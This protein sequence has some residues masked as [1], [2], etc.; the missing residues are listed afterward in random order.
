MAAIKGITIEIGADTKKLQASLNAV[1]KAAGGTQTE[2]RQIERLLKLDPKN[3]ELLA[4]KQQVLGKALENSKKK[5]EE[6]KKADEELQ[7]QSQKDEDWAERQRLLQREIIKTQ[8]EINRLGDEVDGTAGKM[9]KLGKAGDKINSAMSAT[10]KAYT[11]AVV[12][13][14]TAAISLGMAFEESMAGASTLFGD[15]NVD[16]EALNQKMLE[17]SERTNIAA[18]ALGGAL[19]NALSAGVPA[20]DDMSEALGFLEGSAKLAKAGFTDIDTAMSATVKTLNAYGLGMEHADTVQKILI[21]TQNKG[22]TTVGQLG[23]AL[24]QV[25]PTAAAMNVSFDQVGAAIAN[26]TARGT[27]TEQSVTQLNALF[28]ELG[29]SGT[30]AQKSLQAATKGTEYAGKGFSELMAEGV[31]LSELLDLISDYAKKNNKSMLDMFSSIEA[32]KAALSNSAEGAAGFNEALA[33]MG[34]T[35]DVVGEAYDKVTN[36]SSERFKASINDLKNAAISLFLDMQPQISGFFDGIRKGIE[37]FTAHKTGVI[38][39]IKAIGAGLLTWNAVQVVSKTVTAISAL[40]K[41]LQAATAAQTALN[42]AQMTNVIGLVAA[43]IAALTT[44]VVSLANAETAAEKAAREEA[45]ALKELHEE[46]ENRLEE[47]KSFEAE[48]DRQT[49][50]DLE[51]IETTKKLAEELRT[52]AD[53]SGYVQE[54][55]RERAEF[56]LREL[57]SALGT[58]AEM[59]DGV[60]QKYNELQ[61]SIVGAIQAKEVEALMEGAKSKYDEAINNISAARIAQAEAYKRLQEV[62]EKHGVTL[63]AYNANIKEHAELVAKLPSLYDAAYE[64]GD[65]TEYDKI[66]NRISELN[67]IIG[68]QE[69]FIGE[70]AATYKTESERVQQ[71]SDDIYNYSHAT[72]LAAE[73]NYEGAISFLRA[74]TDG[75]QDAASAQ[76]KYGEDTEA[77]LNELLKTYQIRLAQVADAMRIYSETGTEDAKQNLMAALSAFQTAAKEYYDAGGEV[78][79]GFAKGANGTTLDLNPILEQLR[80]YVIVVPDLGQ[81]FA[82]GFIR[83]IKGENGLNVSAAANAAAQLARAALSGIRTEADIHSPSKETGYLGQDFVAGFVNEIAAGEK[84]AEKAAEG[85]AAA[86]VEALARFVPEGVALSVKENTWEVTDETKKHFEDLKLQRDINAISEAEYYARLEG[87]RDSYLEKGTKEWWDY[88]KDLLSYQDKLSDEREKEAEKAQKELE[89]QLEEA[90]K[91]LEKAK[92][93]IQDI[94]NDIADEAISDLEDVISA[95]TSFADKLKGTGDLYYQ[96]TTRVI[97][98]EETFENT[99][100]VLEDLDAQTKMLEDYGAALAAL[101]ERGVPRELLD[102]LQGMSLEEGAGFAGLLLSQ[103]DADFDAYIA[104]WK[105]KQAAAD[106]VS[107]AYYAEDVEN[108]KENYVKGMRDALGGLVLDYKGLGQ[109]Y[110]VAIG[111]GFRSGI[112]SVAAEMQRILRSAMPSIGVVPGQGGAVFASGG[113]VTNTNQTYSPTFNIYNGKMTPGQLVEASAAQYMRD[114]L[115]GVIK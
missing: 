91:K 19:Y 101:R 14:G 85:L 88:T 80:G 25:T 79:N 90:Q 81:D 52:L 37:W 107:A 55:D 68:E 92:D 67:V 3:T 103:S 111:D 29:K 66:E 6:L 50:S 112:A 33:A 42:A 28:A 51:R 105:R 34:T 108:V 17:L 32:G 109:D 2:L 49:A 82:D 115:T 102:I 31:P 41:A 93:N 9:E 69:K 23:N 87:L 75:I 83:G 95:Q 98:G 36:T 70:A 27:K 16:M 35:A 104:S 59:V 76:E 38:T 57:N 72:K 22:I 43:G 18:D 62:E 114:R 46:A 13:G 86:A 96:H 39:A 106:A 45:E 60:I 73:G 97:V 1:N 11:A 63:E 61:G 21:Q 30:V 64:S 113:S 24:A 20:T 78:V 53:E 94:F 99:K 71:Y 4:Q 44:A 10:T 5:L 84:D 54:A 100:L 12:A 74:Q 77:I 89:K 7:K 48:Q 26:M 40:T 65:W 15:A 110:A 47:Y 8:N 58:E 56:I